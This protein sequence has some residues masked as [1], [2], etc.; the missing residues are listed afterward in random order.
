[1]EEKKQITEDELIGFI[2]NKC[3]MNPEQ[4]NSESKLHDELGLDSL[5]VVELSMDIECHFN[6]QILDENIER[7]TTVKELLNGIN[8]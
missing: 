2:A 3:E 6:M 5:D 7:V 1:M 8:K 4:I